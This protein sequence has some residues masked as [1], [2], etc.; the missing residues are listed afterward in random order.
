MTVFALLVEKMK[1]QQ[2][3]DETIMKLSRKDMLIDWENRTI[4][5]TKLSS[6]ST[7]SDMCVLLIFWLKHE[8]TRDKCGKQL[9][10]RNTVSKMSRQ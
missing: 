4:D 5:L 2:K 1:L 9:N 6:T 7:I 10:E 3:G 8:R